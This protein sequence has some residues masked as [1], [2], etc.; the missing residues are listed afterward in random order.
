MSLPSSALF[1]KS[2]PEAETQEILATAIIKLI[3]GGLAVSPIRR[4]LKIGRPASKAAAATIRIYPS[5]KRRLTR[6]IFTMGVRSTHIK[7]AV[8]YIMQYSL[9]TCH[10]V[11]KN[12]VYAVFHSIHFKWNMQIFRTLS[13]LL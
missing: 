4:R 6:R 3:C 7:P 13:R 1:N 2:L 10:R 12:I 9:S 5:A 8:L 11:F